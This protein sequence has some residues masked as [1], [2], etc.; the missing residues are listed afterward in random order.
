MIVAR[1]IEWGRGGATG[2][3]G[4]QTS[5]QPGMGTPVAVPTVMNSPSQYEGQTVTVNGTVADTINPNAFTVQD[6]SAKGKQ[7]LV[8]GAANVIPS[9]KAGDQ[10]QVSGKVQKFNVTAFNTNLGVNLPQSQFK[11]YNGQPAIE[12]SSVTMGGASSGSQSPGG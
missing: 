10:V 8:V 1:Q 5:P 12:A 6:P 3:S 4:A 2:T 7:M 9:L 11:K